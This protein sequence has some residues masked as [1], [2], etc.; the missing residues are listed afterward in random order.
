MGATSRSPKSKQACK[1]RTLHLVE[2][3]ALVRERLR[4]VLELVVPPLLRKDSR[5]ALGARREDRVEIDVDEVVEILCVERGYGVARAV[6]VGEG[7]EERL[8]RAFEQLGERLLRGVFIGS[9]QNRMLEDMWHAGRVRDG[10]A[11]GDAKDL[12]LIIG[13]R[14]DDFCS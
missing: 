6:G 8:E 5:V 2:D 4:R 9:A 10:R 14:R 12:V 3:Y 11:E 13:L 7:V 1:K